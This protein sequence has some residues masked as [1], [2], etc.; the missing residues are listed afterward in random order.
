ME[1]FID[2]FV[3]LAIFATMAALVYGAY[4]LFKDKKD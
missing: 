4:P 3:P 1:T 2:I